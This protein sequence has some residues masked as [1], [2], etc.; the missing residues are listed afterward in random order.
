MQ[1]LM[2]NLMITKAITVHPPKSKTSYKQ[3][4]Q[5]LD[6]ERFYCWG[7]LVLELVGGFV[8]GLVYVF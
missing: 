7:I 4:I 1:H 2:E 8:H 3:D 5:K 6:G